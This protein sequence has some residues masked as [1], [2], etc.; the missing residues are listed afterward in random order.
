M[1]KSKKYKY[2]RKNRDNEYSN[3]KTRKIQM[4]G[5]FKFFNKSAPSTGTGSKPLLTP[6]ADGKSSWW[7]RNKNP[8]EA[9]KKPQNEGEKKSWWQRNKNPEEAKNK[10][11]N[12]GE[13]K[14]WFTRKKKTSRK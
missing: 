1:N 3:D 5:A 4:G 2:F 9:E 10:Q 14:S 13:K 7:Q 6:Q 11:Q 12:E 8:K